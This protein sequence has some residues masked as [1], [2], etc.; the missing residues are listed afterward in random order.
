M[1][2]RLAAMRASLVV[3]EAP[4]LVLEGQ[5]RQAIQALPAQESVVVVLQARLLLQEGDLEARAVTALEQALV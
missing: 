5:L 1:M 4:V 2:G 3:E